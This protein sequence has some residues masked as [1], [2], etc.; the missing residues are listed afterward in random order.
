MAFRR[1]RATVYKALVTLQ[2]KRTRFSSWT[3]SDKK[4]VG[5]ALTTVDAAYQLWHG[6]PASSDNVIAVTIRWQRFLDV[7]HNFS[8][9]YE[10]GV[11]RRSSTNLREAALWT[12]KVEGASNFLMITFQAAHAEFGSW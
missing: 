9:A 8:V 12:D 2:K 11:K 3:A 7:S 4:K 10:S 6:Q 5:L 1:I